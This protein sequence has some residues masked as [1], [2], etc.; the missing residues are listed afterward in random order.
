MQSIG[1]DVESG[2]LLSTA[3]ELIGCCGPDLSRRC[4]VGATLADGGL[5]VRLRHDSD[6]DS[7]VIVLDGVCDQFRQAQVSAE[8][9]VQLGSL[10]LVRDPREHCHQ[11]LFRARTGFGCFSILCL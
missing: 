11:S 4:R 9:S 10:D 6:V 7:T 5:E 1:C 8:E 2:C 3:P